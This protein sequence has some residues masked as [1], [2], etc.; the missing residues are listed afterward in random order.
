MGVVAAANDDFARLNGC[1]RNSRMMSA[2]AAASSPA[3]SGTRATIP[4]VT[5]KSR[6]WIC[7]EKALATMPTGS[8][9]MT[10]PHRIVIA[11]TSLP[12]SVIGTTS[13]YPMVPSVTIDHHMA[14]G[15]VPNLSGCASRSAR[16][17]NVALTSVAPAKITAH[18]NSARRSA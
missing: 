15:I 17:I 12:S 9:I 1:A 11:A 13:P 16:W 10:S 3:N 18:P 7:S 2:I 4:Q 5:T 6:R 14:S 8:A